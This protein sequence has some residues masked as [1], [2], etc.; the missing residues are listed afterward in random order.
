MPRYLMTVAYDGGAYQGWQVQPGVPTVQEVL[1]LV[2]ARMCGA[3]TRI[4][5]SGRTDTGVH[6]RGQAFHFDAARVDIPPAKWTRAMNG[7]LPRDIRILDTRT[8]PDSFHARFDVLHKEYR[9]L[10]DPGPVQLPERRHTC[11]HLPVLPDFSAMQQACTVLQG[12]HDF[13][14]FS[15]DRGDGNTDTVRDLQVLTLRAVGDGLWMVQAIAPG[16]LYKMVRQLVGALLR[17]GN[18]GLSVADLGALLAHPVRTPHIPTAPAHG[19]SLW[20]V[21]YPEAS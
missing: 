17:V 2:L 19:L 3:H 14:A 10:L 6:A 4:H 20:R 9:Y 8:V 15:L 7:N 12:R 16:F 21:T 18:G 1:E 11:L 5:G 13:K